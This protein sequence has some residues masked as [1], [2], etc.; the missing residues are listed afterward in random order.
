MDHQALTRYFE[1]PAAPGERWAVPGA[2]MMA[3]VLGLLLVWA[4]RAPSMPVQVG[5]S[6]EIWSP[7]VQQ[8][9]PAPPPPPPEPPANPPAPAPAAKAPPPPPPAVKQ[10]GPVR[11]GDIGTQKRPKDKEPKKESSER[12]KANKEREDK[13]DAL[14]RQKLLDK[15]LEDSLRRSREAAPAAPTK[16]EARPETRA[17]AKTAVQPSAAQPS[18]AA[19]APAQPAP[20]KVS[21]AAPAPPNKAAPITRNQAAGAGGGSE[22]DTAAQSSGPSSSYAGK[23]IQLVR[24]NTFFNESNLSQYTV[25]V[26]VRAGANGR[27]MSAEIVKSSG[28]PAFDDAVIRGIRKINVLPRDTDGRIPELLL[29]EGMLITIPFNR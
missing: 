15:I 27:I 25:E 7:T 12:E 9:A 18:A 14:E 21:A 13:A 20:A 3:A 26:M 4:A 16:A 23:I 6:A 28:R 17:E 24:E 5:L 2:L 19:P 10:S 1:P 11:E 8:A 29:R 22:K